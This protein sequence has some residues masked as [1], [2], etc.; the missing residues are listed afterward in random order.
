MNDLQQA[1][2]KWNTALADAAVKVEA[3][4][5]G[6]DETE[7]AEGYRFLTRITAAMTEFQMEQSADWPSLVQ[8][9]SPVVSFHLGPG[10]G[11][12][13]TGDSISKPSPSMNIVPV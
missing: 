8:V 3:L 11:E 12:K 2:A 1:W 7:R 4:T 10:S 13:L 9:M 6:R 5:E